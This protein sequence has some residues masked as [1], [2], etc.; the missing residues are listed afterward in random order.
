MAVVINTNSRKLHFHEHLKLHFCC[1]SW[2][3]VVEY[4]EY[5]EFSPVDLNGKTGTGGW[6]ALEFVLSSPGNIIVHKRRTFQQ[7]ACCGRTDCIA[8]IRRILKTRTVYVY[9]NE[10]LFGI[11][12]SSGR[13]ETISPSGAFS[14]AETRCGRNDFVS[15]PMWRFSVR[16]PR[17]H[18]CLGNGACPSG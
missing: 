7:L 16:Q 1:I 9:F 13:R 11:F 3:R 10:L 4:G 5:W 6:F 18:D 14:N 15:K 12:S 2:N 8:F 17:T